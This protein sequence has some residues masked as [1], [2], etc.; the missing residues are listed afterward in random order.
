MKKF[1]KLPLI[2]IFCVLLYSFIPNANSFHN[3]ED[4]QPQDD[5]LELETFGRKT[6]KSHIVKFTPLKVIG[7]VNPGVEFG[8][9]YAYR[10]H[11]SS[12]VMLSYQLPRTIYS[13]KNPYIGAARGYR[14]QYEQKYFPKGNAPFG[15]YYGLELNYLNH[16]HHALVQFV[17]RN[18]DH[19]WYRD[20]IKIV[21][22]VFST[23]FKIGKQYDFRRFTFEYYFGLG[24]KYRDI[25]HLNRK[26]PNDII[27][28]HRHWSIYMSMIQPANEFR[29]S[30]PLNIRIGWKL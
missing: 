17:D 29:F 9:E 6:S 27:V 15:F 12:Q 7:L 19:L 8:Y 21:R 28:P 26:H 3:Q 14:I 13:S 10:D 22:N 30:M 23:S 24:I 18:N 11:F 1:N 25:K 4:L 20:G 16:V 5:S 2:T